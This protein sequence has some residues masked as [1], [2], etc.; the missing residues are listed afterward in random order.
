M[1]ANQ[2]PNQVAAKVLSLL[3]AV[4][5]R[6][7]PEIILVQGDTTTAFAGAFAAFNRKIKI[8][9]IEAGLRSGDALSPF[10]EELNRRLIS[11]LTTLHFCATGGN[12]RNLT[13]E[14]IS[15]K[16]IF[17]CGNTV[18]DASNSILEKEQPSAKIKKLLDE[19]NGFKRILLTTHRRESFGETMAGNL[20]TLRDF[21]EQRTDVCLIFPVHPNPN[22]KRITEKILANREQI[23]LLEPLDYVN[24]C[25]VDASRVA[26]CVRFGRRSGRSSGFRKTAFNFA[27]KHRTSRSD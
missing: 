11:Q 25:R 3:D 12:K 26:D 15:E 9:H 10:P 18:V 22:V 23:F 8:G 5:E 20:K 14:G 1:T 21:I 24:F 7:K 16:S 4:L 13:A 17:L 2:T 6:E 19:T 27:G